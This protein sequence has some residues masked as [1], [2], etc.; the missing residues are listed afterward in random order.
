[1]GFRYRELTPAK[2]RKILKRAGFKKVRQEGSHE[3]WEGVTDGK[4]RI[5]TVDTLGSPERDIR[6]QADKIND[7]AVWPQ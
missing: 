2:V 5:V 4:R 3:Q 7:Q 6:D 1:M